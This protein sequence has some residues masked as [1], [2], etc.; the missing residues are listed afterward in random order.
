MGVNTFPK[1]ICPKT[2]V[3]ARLE[4]ELT[5]YDSAVQ[6]FQIYTPSEYKFINNRIF[7]HVKRFFFFF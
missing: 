2:N 7:C 6:R 5:D 3:I 1:A 4:F